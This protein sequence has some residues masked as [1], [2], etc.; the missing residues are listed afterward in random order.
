MLN[1]AFQ[2]QSPNQK[3]SRGRG[4]IFKIPANYPAPSSFNELFSVSINFPPEADQPL[5]EKV[6][7]IFVKTHEE[8]YFLE[9]LS[10]LHIPLGTHNY[11]VREVQIHT[12]NYAQA[13]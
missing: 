7:R 4:S 1:N 12:L 10:L 11:N 2:E 9:S 6:E 3:Y 5:A 13:Q 8:D